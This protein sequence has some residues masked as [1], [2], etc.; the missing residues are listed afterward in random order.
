MDKACAKNPP[1]APAPLRRRALL[2]VALAACS[3]C[4]WQGSMRPTVNLDIDSPAPHTV[5]AW[6]Y[7]AP[8]G[9]P[10]A[11]VYNSL[12]VRLRTAPPFRL[13]FPDG[14]VA[15]SRE[16]D[17]SLLAAH[18]APV[19]KGDKGETVSRLSVAKGESNY[20]I[21]VHVGADG[22]ADHLWLYACKHVM[23]GVLGT[24]DGARAFDFPVR[25]SEIAEL[26]GGPLRMGH[27]FVIL[28]Y[29]CV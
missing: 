28:G 22:L 7:P 14:Y 21:V 23:R 19:G 29:D 1:P 3:S 25:Q 4:S 15:N 2:A 9:D 13:A 5:Q 26:F 8:G 12:G 16:I 18:L 6:G 17:A 10:G 27:D 11:A 20:S 24:A